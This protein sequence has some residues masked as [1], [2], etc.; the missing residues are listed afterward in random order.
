M[1]IW[2][3][4]SRRAA[5]RCEGL[6]GHFAVTA[7]TPD[8]FMASFTLQ[9][10]SDGIHL[11]WVGDDV[12]VLDI[13]QDRYACLLS[14]ASYLAP[15]D[16]LDRVGVR[17]D[18]GDQLQAAGWIGTR[19][20]QSGRKPPNSPKRFISGTRKFSATGATGVALNA[21]A[22][23]RQ[24]Q[25]APLR[26]LLRIADGDRHRARHARPDEVRTRALV[27]RFFTVLPWLPRQGLCLHR[28]F[29]LL[30]YLARHGIDCDWVFGVRTWP[31]AA[32]CWLMI[33]DTVLGDELDRVRAF[34][35]ILVA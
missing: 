19:T 23:Q 20:E 25:G 28:S 35:P 2:K 9:P 8:L 18:V 1:S 14:G 3:P 32:H 6:G 5:S 21:L 24:F 13:G 7:Q 17:D 15:A 10:L 4:R 12:V 16:T 30:R 34:T 11:A 29:M 22:G 27:G 26:K 33:D 31:F